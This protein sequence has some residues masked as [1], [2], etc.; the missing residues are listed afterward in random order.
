MAGRSSQARS[1]SIEPNSSRQH[2]R[3][4][5]R[6]QTRSQTPHSSNR[7]YSASGNDSDVAIPSRRRRRQRRGPDGGGR[8]EGQKR[9]EGL[10]GVEEVEDVVNR[11]EGKDDKD[12]LKLRLDLN[13]D[14]AVEIKARVH[15][16]LTLTLL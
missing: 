10:P 15:G 11:D 8:I 1:S 14:V 12:T 13:L 6:R 2:Q 3:S 9:Y 7:S 16:D 4:Q 5:S